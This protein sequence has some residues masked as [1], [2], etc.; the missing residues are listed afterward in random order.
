MLAEQDEGACERTSDRMLHFSCVLVF[1]TAFQNWVIFTVGKSAWGSRQPNNSCHSSGRG[2]CLSSQG[3][4]ESKMDLRRCQL[5]N[6]YFLDGSCFP[7]PV[8]RLEAVCFLIAEDSGTLGFSPR[9]HSCMGN[10]SPTRPNARSCATVSLWA[11]DRQMPM[12]STQAHGRHC[13][14]PAVQVATCPGWV[15]CVDSR[16]GRMWPVSF[17]PSPP[18][19]QGWRHLGTETICP[20]VE[21]ARG[22]ESRHGGGGGYS[23]GNRMQCS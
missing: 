7:A 17:A 12:V 6:V 4:S 1:V 14:Y 20:A 3:Q 11:D 23:S 5:Q 10:T 19:C 22:V 2:A 15:V 8:D 18:P 9:G 21:G 16:R 13:P